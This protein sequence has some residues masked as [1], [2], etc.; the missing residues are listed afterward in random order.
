MDV[1]TAWEMNE[2]RK[3]R[4]ARGMG[5]GTVESGIV[6]GIGKTRGRRERG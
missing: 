5:D 6:I 3:K 1:R 4:R 2:N